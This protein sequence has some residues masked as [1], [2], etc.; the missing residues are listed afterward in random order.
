M[1]ISCFSETYEELSDDQIRDRTNMLFMDSLIQR[2]EALE[3]KVEKLGAISPPPA[4]EITKAIHTE[5]LQIWNS[6]KRVEHEGDN[7]KHCPLP[8]KPKFLD[9]KKAEEQKIYA[10]C[11]TFGAPTGYIFKE[12]DN[13]NTVFGKEECVHHSTTTPC[14]CVL[15]ML[16]GK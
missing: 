6:L 16:E 13:G 2:I 14:L 9:P 10:L 4:H 7:F 1:E 8:D 5:I 3:N 11:K 15:K 12:F